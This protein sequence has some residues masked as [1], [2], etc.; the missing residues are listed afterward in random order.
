VGCSTCHGRIDQMEVVTQALPL[1]MS[2][3]RLPSQRSVPRL[4]HELTTMDWSAPKDQ[5]ESAARIKAA[6]RLAPPLDC[7]GCHR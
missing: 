7:T 4:D 6:R 5:L 3:C 2:W 1:S